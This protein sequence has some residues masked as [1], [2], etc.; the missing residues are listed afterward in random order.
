MLL[1]TL[2]VSGLGL[3]GCS[4]SSDPDTPRTPAERLAAAQR[5]ADEASSVHLVLRSRD[6]P[7]DAVGLLGA[8][9]VGTHAPAFQGTLTARLSGSSVDIDVVAVDGLLFVK[10]PFTTS[11]VKTNPEKYGAPDPAVLFTPGRGVTSLLTA[12]VDPQAADDAREGTEVLSQ[13]TGT[14]PGQLVARLLHIGT[15]TQDYQVTYGL[16]AEGQLRKA[17]LNGTFFRGS[18]STYELLLDRYGE[19]VDIQRP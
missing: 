9:G 3:A 4:G 8:E 11:Y 7:D 10:F 6:V 16:T 2:L 18:T 5:Q 1:L 15:S 13:I 17:T 19:P 12:T 14:L